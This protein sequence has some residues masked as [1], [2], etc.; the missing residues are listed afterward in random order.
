MVEELCK[1]CGDAL[2]A[3]AEELEDGSIVYITVCPTC[4]QTRRMES[5]TA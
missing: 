3:F 1:Y 5:V 2:I 4:Y